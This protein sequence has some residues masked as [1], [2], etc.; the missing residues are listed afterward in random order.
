[1]ASK[2]DAPVVRKQNKEYNSKI[3]KTNEIKQKCSNIPDWERAPE[4]FYGEG[5]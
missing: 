2:D 3:I 4:N 5:K 1:M